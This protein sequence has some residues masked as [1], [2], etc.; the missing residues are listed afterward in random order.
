MAKKAESMSKEEREGMQKLD[1]IRKAI[2]DGEASAEQ[3]KR[4]VELKTVIGQ[5]RFVRIGSK[6][7]PKAI[8]AV[9][10]IGN[11]SGAGY[12]ATEAQVKATVKALREA[13]DE[14][15][16]S[17]TGKKETAAGFVLPTT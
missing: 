8:K 4:I 7:I 15:E 13:V 3:K 2:G 6:R 14:V 16:K 17:L 9:K 1:G 12:V 5:A 10:Q 11:L